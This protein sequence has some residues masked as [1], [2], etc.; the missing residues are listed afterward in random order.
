LLADVASFEF[1]P[2]TIGMIAIVSGCHDEYRGFSESGLISIHLPA[3]VTVIGESCFSRCG[4]LASITFQSGSL[5]SALAWEAFSRSGLTSIHLPASVTVI[6]RSCFS[7]CRSLVSIT[8]E[9]GSQLSELANEA[10]CKSGLTSIHLPASVTV[11]GT[12]CFSDCRSLVSITF[13]AAS[14]FGGSGPHLLAGLPLG[15]T[16]WR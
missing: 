15:E 4:S 5:L 8:F 7:Y 3:S 14:K 13:D 16:D 12:R 1:R 10:F 6:G 2:M 9:S 11:I